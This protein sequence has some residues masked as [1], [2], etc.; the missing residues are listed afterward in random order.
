MQY[1]KNLNIADLERQPVEIHRLRKQLA[2]K[3]AQ[4]M[5]KAKTG[6]QFE[7]ILASESAY[8]RGVGDR[9]HSFLDDANFV[10]N[11]HQHMPSKAHGGADLKLVLEPPVEGYLSKQGLNRIETVSTSRSRPPK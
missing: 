5:E 1:L 7:L 3:E 10:A 11:I 4:I 8:P 9:L 6:H 2:D